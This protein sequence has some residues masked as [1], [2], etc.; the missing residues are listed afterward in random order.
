MDKILDKKSQKE[1]NKHRNNIYLNNIINRIDKA[2]TTYIFNPA[3]IVIQDI[4]LVNLEKCCT[5]TGHNYNN[6]NP[7]V[8]TSLQLIDNPNIKLSKT[9][10][11]NFY[12]TFQPTNYA[13]VFNLGKNHSLSTLPQTSYFYPWIHKCPSNEFRA[14]L[15]GPKDISNVEHRVLRLKNLIESVTKFGYKPDNKDIVEGYILL[16]NNDYRFLITSGHH[17]VAV[18]T[19]LY[20]DSNYLCTV[21]YE[22]KRTNIKIVNRNDSINWPGVKSN[23]IP[24]E[25]ALSL[26][27]S[28]FI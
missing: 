10:L 6:D 16:K 20:K 5:F 7:L 2:E 18:L 13:Q 8:N 21:K 11:Y 25:D 3:N 23:Y 27:D 9:Y 1:L 4:F 24:Q 15:F 12:K 14:G 17:R 22:K 28:F 19:A 26:F